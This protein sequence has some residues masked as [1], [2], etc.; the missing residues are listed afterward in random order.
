[1]QPVPQD[2]DMV[3]TARSI[4]ECEHN[5]IQLVQRES[6]IPVPQIHAVELNPNCKVMAQFMLMDCLRG[7]VGMDLDMRVPA[8]HKK[9]VFARMAEIQ[10]SYNSW[11]AL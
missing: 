1:M 10:V 3:D 11:L 4:M 2:R 7:N 5:A 8:N 9:H 6:S